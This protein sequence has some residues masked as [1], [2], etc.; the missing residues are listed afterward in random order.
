[1]LGKCVHIKENRETQG[2][3]L[4]HPNIECWGKISKYGS[5]IVANVTG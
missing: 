1:M 3:N 2:N 5:E 4:T